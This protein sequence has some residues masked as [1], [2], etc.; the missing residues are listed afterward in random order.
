[1]VHVFPLM[2]ESVS[3][4]VNE[5]FGLA[6]IAALFCVSLIVIFCPD[7]SDSEQVTGAASVIGCR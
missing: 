4:I 2:V 3:R 1:M 7:T 6:Q 5:L